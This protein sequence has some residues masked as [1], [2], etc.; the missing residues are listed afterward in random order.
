MSDYLFMLENHL[1]AAQNQALAAVQAAG[2]DAGLTVWLTGGAMRDMLL[3]APIRDLDFTVEKDALAIAA[4]LAGKGIAVLSK[5]PLERGAELEFP[6]G[7]RGSIWNARTEKYPKPGGKPEIAPATIHEDLK[8]RDFSINAIGLSVNRGSKGLLID[9]VNGEADLTSRELR[10][11]NSYAFLDDPNRML[12][13]IRFQYGLGFTVASRTKS[14]FENALLE[15]VHHLIPP[16]AI[17]SEIRRMVGVPNFAAALTAMVDAGIA[18]LAAPALGSER[19]NTAGLE[20]L[21]QLV[22]EELPADQ[23]NVLLAYLFVMTEK[24]SAKDRTETLKAFALDAEGVAA[25]KEL[26]ASAKELGAKL[27]APSMK[28]ALIYETVSAATP[29]QILLALYKNSAEIV[30]ER[31]QAYFQMYLPMAQEITEADVLETGAKPGTA[32]YDKAYKTLITQKLNAKPK[33][34]EEVETMS[35][36]IIPTPMVRGRG[37]GARSL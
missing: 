26:E 25:F 32:K 10:A 30:T 3:G 5:D 9:P 37:A 35:P 31:V 34:P 24:M 20:K 23:R 21:E 27:Q 17:V 7:V 15:E 33:P 4:V 19:R 14:Q 13:L 36:P 8:R 11:A 22:Q 2:T 18:Q 16:A 1:D 6:G 12:R 28:P 29:D